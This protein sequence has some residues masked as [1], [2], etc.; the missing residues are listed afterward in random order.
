MREAIKRHLFSRLTHRGIVVFSL[1]RSERSRE[2]FVLHRL[3]RGSSFIKPPCLSDSLLN[4]YFT[5][6]KQLTSPGLRRVCLG[7][8][9]LSIYSA[10][11][12]PPVPSHAEQ[13]KQPRRGR[14]CDLSISSLLTILAT[15]CCWIG[16]LL[17]VPTFGVWQS[18]G[19]LL[20]PK[21]PSVRDTRRGYISSRYLYDADCCARQLSRAECTM[22]IPPSSGVTTSRA[23]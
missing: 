22:A 2:S 21:T 9:T 23:M 6:D 13:G 8:P 7:A 20:C 17:R 18:R 11:S 16:I 15:S 4:A 1:S 19:R 3:I 10:S 5:V 14:M 12:A